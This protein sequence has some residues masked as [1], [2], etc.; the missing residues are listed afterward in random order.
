MSDLLLTLGHNSSA[1]VAEGSSIILGYETERV[2]LQKSD[3]QFPEAILERLR[4]SDAGFDH[5]D[6]AYVTHWE[7]NNDVNLMKEKYWS[8]RQVNAEEIITQESL[9]LTHHDTHA[10]GALAFAGES[11]PRQNTQVLVVD[12]FGSLGEHASIYD[13]LPDG[14][15]KLRL[16]LYGYDTSIGLMYQYATQFLGMKMHEDEYKLLGYQSK[17]FEHLS[18]GS[19]EIL[20]TQIDKIFKQWHGATRSLHHMRFD[21][22]MSLEALPETASMWSKR[23]ADVLNRIGIG[24]YHSTEARAAIGHLVQSLCERQILYLASMYNPRNLIV[25]GGVFYNVAV[26]AMLASKVPGMFCAFPLAGDQGG[27]LGLRYFHTRSLEIKD[28][29]WGWRKSALYRDNYSDVDGLYFVD[30]YDEA[31]ALA[32]GALL[33]TGFFN[34]VRGDMEFGPRALCNTSTIAFANS[35]AI[36]QEINRINGRNTVMPFAP[37]VHPAFYS[38]HFELT[39]KVWR[40]EK[41]MITALPCVDWRWPGG[42]LHTAFGQ[43]T[44]RPQ[45]YDLKPN[46]LV[47]TLLEEYGVLIN[48][49]FNVHGVPIVLDHDHIVASHKS[50]RNHNKNVITIVME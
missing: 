36:V 27:A 37:V 48:T 14:T 43:E 47:S 20:S 30:D 6:R 17:V 7:P 50:Q 23:F 34:L 26:N 15:I 40:S 19:M 9:G 31:L 12:G 46:D 5:F 38:R 22:V 1:I 49:S 2:T 44:G 33:K 21:P 29:F 42:S 45:V 8:P 24:D 28:L 18:P 35:S 16:R 39:N 11:F 10:W 25:S 32:R 4:R 3:S 41:F 13:M